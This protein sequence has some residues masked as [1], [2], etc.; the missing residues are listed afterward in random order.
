MSGDYCL[1]SLYRE[2]NLPKVITVFILFYSVCSA[3]KAEQENRED[4]ICENERRKESRYWKT[5]SLRSVRTPK[6]KRRDGKKT[7]DNAPKCPRREKRRS[8]AS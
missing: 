8:G 4:E 3:L 2:T 6:S 5:N 1:R 7:E